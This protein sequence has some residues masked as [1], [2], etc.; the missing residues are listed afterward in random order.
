MIEI[1]LSVN[2]SRHG[3][4]FNVD[5]ISIDMNKI[6]KYLNVSNHQEISDELYQYATSQTD[7]LIDPDKLNN[8]HWQH[9]PS[10]MIHCPKL[11]E[12]L[13]NQYLMPVKMG[14]IVIHTKEWVPTHADHVD[15]YVRLLWPVKNCAGSETKFYNLK[16]SQGQLIG[17][18]YEGW[19]IRYPADHS[20]NVIDQFE[21]TG[22]IVLDTSVPHS[23]H[24]DK[25]LDDIR[26]S[27][28]IAFDPTLAISKSVNAWFDFTH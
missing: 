28:T 2:L 26:I 20:G 11:R 21:L 25:I 24:P 22:P 7:L 8:L 14:F 5:Q 13:N 27:F 1:C 19:Y 4:V 15:H 10:I 17:A 16:K 3:S 6:W 12:F 9:V 18:E 23:I